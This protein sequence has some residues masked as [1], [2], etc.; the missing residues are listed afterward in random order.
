MELT[1]LQEE[2]EKKVTERQ[3]AM[4]Q[5]QEAQNNVVALDSRVK[6]LTGAAVQLQELIQRATP[7]QTEEE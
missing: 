2:F 4:N 7:L 6:E 3:Q 5:L 1:E